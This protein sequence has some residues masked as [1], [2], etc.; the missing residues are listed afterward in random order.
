MNQN[1]HRILQ[2]LRAAPDYVSGEKLC[3]QLG[4]TR[5][6]GWKHI[7]SLRSAGY[8]I[9][10]RPRCGY[11]LTS[12]PNALIESEV[13]PLLRTRTVGRAYTYTASTDSTNRT[14]SELAAQ[15]APDGAVVVADRQT[16]G[17]GRLSRSWFSPPGRNIYCSIVLRPD[18][19]PDRLP[20]M[21]LVM[22]VAAVRAI[23]ALGVDCD[24]GL[25]WPNDLFLA[26]RKLGG[27]LCEMSAEIDH[28]HYVVVGIGI[29]VNIQPDEFPPDV[30]EIATSLSAA[31]GTEISRPRLLA[32]LLS[33]MEQQYESWLDRGLEGALPDWQ[34]LDV[35]A[36]RQVRFS[37]RNGPVTGT[38]CGLSASG[39]LRVETEGGQTVEVTHGDVN[40][41]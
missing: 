3:E 29:N 2:L 4:I 39:G 13:L 7:R 19:P 6:A 12:A 37:T 40:P 8:L 9:E 41:V 18:V 5:A 36:G 11:R 28:V 32:E 33:Q 22:G 35:L 31:A 10:S 27:I 24:L 15:G 25:K 17:R 30:A 21:S 34:R 26:G 14:A 20:E 23:R 16:Q 38:A 1:T